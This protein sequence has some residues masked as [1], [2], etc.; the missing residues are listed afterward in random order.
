MPKCPF[1][2]PPPRTPSNYFSFWA[3]KMTRVSKIAWSVQSFWMLTLHDH[4]FDF[5]S[6]RH[7]A[8]KI[9]KKN[10]EKIH[11]FFFFCIFESPE[12]TFYALTMNVVYMKKFLQALE[13]FEILKSLKIWKK[14]KNFQNFK[15]FKRL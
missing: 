1:L 11:F 2:P 6:T 9:L 15:F 14:N 13:K 4:I 8:W 7:R 10:N 5:T 3:M 12:M